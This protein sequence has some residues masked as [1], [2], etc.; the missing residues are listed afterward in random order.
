MSTPLDTDALDRALMELDDLPMNWEQLTGATIKY[1]QPRLTFIC[2]Q[3]NP[4]LAALR[5]SQAEQERHEKN[6][7]AWKDTAE[8]WGR[9]NGALHAEVASRAARE[10]ALREAAEEVLRVLDIEVGALKQTAKEASEPT[11]RYIGVTLMA[12]DEG[13]AVSKLRAALA[14]AATP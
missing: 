3:V 6:Y 7:L 8:E 12:L 10:A 5:A 14:G 11:A 2:T 9:L 1:V 13:E 4:L